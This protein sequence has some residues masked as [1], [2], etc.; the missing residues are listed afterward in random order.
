MGT[1]T[2][3]LLEEDVAL[4]DRLSELHASLPFA[5]RAHAVLSRLDGPAPT[6]D[7]EAV[8]LVVR[9]ELERVAGGA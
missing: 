3:R 2:V 5:A 1:K 6:V 9:E 7:V 4:L 8:R